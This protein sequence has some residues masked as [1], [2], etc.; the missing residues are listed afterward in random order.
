M[1]SIWDGERLRGMNGAREGHGTPRNGGWR[2]ECS[3]HPL[4]FMTCFMDS[5]SLGPLP[6]QTTDIR[7]Q[8]PVSPGF[9]TLLCHFLAVCLQLVS[10][11]GKRITLHQ[12]S[13]V[14]CGISGIQWT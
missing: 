9:E 12:P 4:S 11:M 10:K 8:D 7:T 1:E 13:Q 14:S 6:V 5:C 3:S 2:D